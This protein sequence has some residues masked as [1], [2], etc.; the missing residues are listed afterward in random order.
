MITP[1]I[2]TQAK[3]AW[4]RS[5]EHD[6]F[7]IA[8]YGKNANL[9]PHVAA[10]TPE[11][12]V[13]GLGYTRGGMKLEGISFGVTGSRAWMDWSVD[14]RIEVASISASGALVYNRSKNDLAMVV[15]AFEEDIISRNGPWWLEFAPAGETATI[16][17]A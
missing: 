2:C 17:I 10:Y 3:L 11:G 7:W 14:P 15:L 1:G 6:D 16:R 5:M 9:N 12:E 13:V 8:L 4:L